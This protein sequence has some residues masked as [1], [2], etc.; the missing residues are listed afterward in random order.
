MIR[1]FSILRR[2]RSLF[3]ALALFGLIEP[4]L[5]Q[6]Q[7]VYAADA[8]DGLVIEIGSSG[9]VSNVFSGF[10][11]PLGLAINSSGGVFVANYFG[12]PPISEISPAG[13]ITTFS[14]DSN[15]V[16]ADSLAFSPNGT[17][18]AMGNNPNANYDNSSFY[19]VN[20]AGVAAPADL[21]LAPVLI[22]LST[23][24]GICMLVPNTF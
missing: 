1:V 4:G 21:S 8:T 9:S 10:P 20:S 13:N 15:I 24:A 23:Q 11:Y 17:L 5:A 6:A 19:I 22:W 3:L 16:D 12:S 14:S 7:T 18:W 2:H